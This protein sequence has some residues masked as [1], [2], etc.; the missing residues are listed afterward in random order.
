MTILSLFEGNNE[1][2]PIVT[3]IRRAIPL[4]IVKNNLIRNYELYYK[5]FQGEYTE[6]CLNL[7]N[8]KFE[9]TSLNERSEFIMENGLY[10]FILINHLIQIEIE[11]DNED[12][13]DQYLESLLINPEINFTKERKN[14][15][16][17]ELYLFG[18]HI[19]TAIRN[20]CWKL[21]KKI[22]RKGK[23]ESF[24]FEKMR[25]KYSKEEKKKKLL[26]NV[27]KFYSNFVVHIEIFRDNQLQK[28]FFP[29]LPFCKTLP[30]EIKNNFN[31]KVN[32]ATSKIKVEELMASA[33]NFIK[34]MKHEEELRLF[35][36][37]NKISGLIVNHEKLWKKSAF[38][39]NI[40]IN[41]II[42]VSYTSKFVPEDA[43]SSQRN[44]LRLND[45]YFFEQKEFD[46][47]WTVIIVLGTINLILG[48]TV[49]VLFLIKKA[50]LMIHHVWIGFFESKMNRFLKI[51]K[52]FLKVLISFYICL[53]DMEFLYYIIYILMIMSGLGI[54]PFFFVFNLTDYL[55]ID[56]LK[57]VIQAIW[58]PRKQLLLALFLLIL[59]EYY[60][61]L[62]G[63]IEFYNQYNQHCN[64]F[65]VC[66][67]T[68]FDQT[69]KVKKN[70]KHII[71]C[72]NF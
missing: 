33:P 65:W 5:Y 35:F 53:N 4:S 57:N 45:P 24:I 31:E 22:S 18:N 1:K 27:M 15:I 26:S 14:N 3:K 39:I 29:L 16:F 9:E 48:A 40:L 19:I 56:E 32:R 41:F 67:L 47:T 50:P 37:K 66:F 44:Y 11:K 43:T 8:E 70:L 55:K 2:S 60:F 49:V 6:N 52:G 72:K 17:H 58:I 10:T 51:W 69:F 61:S 64:R 38:Y 71:F 13:E 62:I 12:E 34:I 23:R 20:Y 7:F 59:V 21:T 28:I 46:Q 54:H 36:N 42:I 63:Y 30:K 68:T 25:S